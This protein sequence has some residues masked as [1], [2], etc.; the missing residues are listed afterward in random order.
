MASEIQKNLATIT[1]K[2]EKVQSACSEHFAIKHLKSNTLKIKAFMKEDDLTDTKDV[3]IPE[4][5][6]T[7]PELSVVLDAE[8]KRFSELGSASVNKKIKYESPLD[9][10]K[11]PLTT[12]KASDDDDDSGDKYDKLIQ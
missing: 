3:A 8:V 4:A 11:I 9:F 2:C 12:T 5:S 1:D 7:P 10:L 6:N